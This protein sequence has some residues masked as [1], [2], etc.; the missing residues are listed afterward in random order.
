M[1]IALAIYTYKNSLP[2]YSSYLF[3]GN[4][5]LTSWCRGFG[6][7]ALG[8]YF[9]AAHSPFGLLYSGCQLRIPTQRLTD[10]YRS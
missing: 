6:V 8:V 7:H 1:G 10:I 3:S 5:R 9:S 2:I 4:D